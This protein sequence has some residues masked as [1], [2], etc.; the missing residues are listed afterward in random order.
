MRALRALRGLSGLQATLDAL[1]SANCA[2]ARCL[3]T[4]SGLKEALAEKIPKEQVR[5][6]VC[7]RLT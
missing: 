1:G 2:S 5:S 7:F 4:S 6:F 3:A